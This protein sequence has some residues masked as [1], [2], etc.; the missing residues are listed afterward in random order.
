M[1]LQCAHVSD[2]RWGART[3]TGLRRQMHDGPGSDRNRL[4]PLM[5][6][7]DEQTAGTSAHHVHGISQNRSSQNRSFPPVE[8]RAML[9]YPDLNMGRV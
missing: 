4:G 7:V 8:R 2:D 9:G 6:L 3:G 1:T 5:F